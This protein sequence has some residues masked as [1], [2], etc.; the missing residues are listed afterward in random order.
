MVDSFC[1][2]PSGVISVPGEQGFV[3]RFILSQTL[4]FQKQHSLLAIPGTCQALTY[5]YSYYPLLRKLFSRPS[6]DSHLISFTFLLKSIS[7]DRSCPDHL[8]SFSILLI[9][10]HNT[11][12]TCIFNIYLLFNSLTV[13]THI[14]YKLSCSPLHP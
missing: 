3:V 5:F 12:H 13:F 6:H 11:Y 10:L 1:I 14:E 7:T 8:P 2:S 4:L 9:F